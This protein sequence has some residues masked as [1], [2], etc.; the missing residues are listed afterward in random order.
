MIPVISYYHRVR[1]PLFS[2]SEWRR[3]NFHVIIL[4]PN[5]DKVTVNLHVDIQGIGSSHR[6]RQHGKDV[7]KE[8]E[9]IKQEYRRLRGIQAQE[10]RTIV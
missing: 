5:K 2:S 3:Q 1:G 7:T 10:T 9:R 4:D 6:S 8:F